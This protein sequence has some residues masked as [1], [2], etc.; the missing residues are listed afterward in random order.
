MHPDYS[1]ASN[2]RN[3]TKRESET[4]TYM[5]TIVRLWTTAAQESITPNNRHFSIFK[6]NRQDTTSLLQKNNGLTR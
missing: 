2:S 1:A 5:E 3:D 4:T 6:G